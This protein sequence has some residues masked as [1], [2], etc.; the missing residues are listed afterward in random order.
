MREADLEKIF[1]QS[2]EKKLQELKNFYLSQIYTLARSY[3][4]TVLLDPRAEQKE[5][6][7]LLTDFGFEEFKTMLDKWL[8]SGHMVW[9]IT[10]NFS[11]EKALQV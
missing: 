11:K 2:K 4:N 8:V 6:S 1:S 3:V 9:F 5:I 7:A 10:G